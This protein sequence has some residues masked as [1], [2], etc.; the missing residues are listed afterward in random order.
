[1]KQAFNNK[2]LNKAT[3]RKWIYAAAISGVLITGVQAVKNV[4]NGSVD[5]KAAKASTKLPSSISVNI[6]YTDGTGNSSYISTKAYT[7]KL[8]T[9]NGK[10]VYDLTDIKNIQSA[11]LDVSRIPDYLDPN[12]ESQYKSNDAASNADYVF[13]TVTRKVAEDQANGKTTSSNKGTGTTTSSNNG[14][15]TTENTTNTSANTSSSKL[16]PVTF[17]NHYRPSDTATL[18]IDPQGR[19]SIDVTPNAPTENSNVPTALTGQNVYNF[20]TKFWHADPKSLPASI[21]LTDYNKKYEDYHLERPKVINFKDAKNN[22]VYSQTVYG[23]DDHPM[24]IGEVLDQFQTKYKY[25]EADPNNTYVKDRSIS[26]GINNDD[27][28]AFDILVKYK[29]N[30]PISGSNQTVEIKND[31]STMSDTDFKAKLAEQGYQLVDDD[32]PATVDFSN[33]GSYSVK[34]ITNS[35]PISFVDQHNGVVYSTNLPASA[36]NQ[37]ISIQDILDKVASMGVTPDTNNSIVQ[38]KQV[39]A[40]YNGKFVSIN[41]TAPVH[42]LTIKFI[43]KSNGNEVVAPLEKDNVTNFESFTIADKV[44]ELKT[45]NYVPEL[46]ALASGFNS[47]TYDNFS[48]S[49]VLNPSISVSADGTHTAT[50]YVDSTE[51]TTANTNK[52]GKGYPLSFKDANGNNISLT[53]NSVNPTMTPKEFQKALSDQGYTLSQADVD[54]LG[55]NSVDLNKSDTGLTIS[56]NSI[57]NNVHPIYVSYNDASGKNHTDVVNISSDNPTMS[58]DDL[59]KALSNQGY[60]LTDDQKN[61]LGQRVNFDSLDSRNPI[62]VTTN[63]DA[64]VTKSYPQS[65]EYN[66]G[67]GNIQPIS[68][69]IDSSS[70]NMSKDAY[71][72]AL[73][74]KGYALTDDQKNKLPDVIDLTSNGTTVVTAKDNPQTSHTQTLKDNNNNDVIVHINSSTSTISAYEYEKQLSDQGVTLSQDSK[75]KIAN[76]SVDLTDSTPGYTVTKSTD[77][78]S[79]K[80]YPQ[81]VNV[82]KSDGSYVP[83]SISITSGTSVISRDEYISKLKSLG[84]DVS[85][86]D[87]IP[88]NVDLDNNKGGYSVEQPSSDAPISYKQMVVLPDNSQVAVYINSKTP[89]ISRDDLVKALADQGYTLTD[90]GSTSYTLGSTSNPISVKPNAQAVTTH[91]QTVKIANGD[92]TFAT[93]TVYIPSSNGQLTAS[94]YF[95]AMS[96]QGYTISDPSALSDP[97]SV[98]SDNI[99]PVVVPNAVAHSV[100]INVDGQQ[101]TINV[102]SQNPY[103]NK[104]DFLNAVSAQ[105]YTISDPNSLPS[106]VQL[107]TK[108]VYNAEN[109][110]P[111][112]YIFTFNS[113]DKTKSVEISHDTPL[114]TKQDLIKQLQQKGFNITDSGQLNDIIN[115]NNPDDTSKVASLIEGFST[116]KMTVGVVGSGNTISIS[117]NN[118]TISKQDFINRVE[119]NGYKV[120]NP[121]VLGDKL[122]LTDPTNFSGLI[123]AKAENVSGDTNSNKDDSNN[124]ESNARYAQDVKVAGSN[125]VVKVE[126]TNK[127]MTKDDFVKYLASKGYK[128]SDASKLP[129]TIDLTKSLD[130]IEVVSDKAQTTTNNTESNSSNSGQ[131]NSNVSNSNESNARYAQDVKVAGSN[132]VVKVESTNKTMTKDD[133]VKYLASKG[134]KVSDASKLPATIDLTKSLDG[135][136][137]VSDKVQTT[138]NNTESNSSN[139]GQT[140]SNVSNSNESN[141][142]YA[143]DVKVAGSNEV[144]KVESANKTMT[145]DDFVKYLASK[146]YKV[147][148]ASKLPATIDLTKSLDGIEVVSDKAQSTN[149]NSKDKEQARKT[150]TQYVKIAGSNKAIKVESANKTITKNEFIKYLA[151]KGYKVSDASKLPATIDLT[152]SIKGIEVVSKSS[153]KASKKD[154]KNNNNNVRNETDHRGQLNNNEGTKKLPQTGDNTNQSRSFGFGLISIVLGFILA[155]FGLRRKD[156]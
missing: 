84:Y 124:N 31:S 77:N 136:E 112:G 20:L 24:T 116:Y 123:I 146:G 111:G 88:E 128:V 23:A 102:G 54:K 21:S 47:Q 99:N 6:L 139:S 141:A 52:T 109:N 150:Y 133:F 43:D 85:N 104:S 64:N 65:L 96:D 48:E 140:N 100:L 83:T 155:I 117:S 152:K 70:Q 107:D 89:T 73:S 3:S 7:A 106:Q 38:N 135:I 42:K 78:N 28:Q 46:S 25:A 154:V 59:A 101:K 29:M 50:I 151:A 82:K 62:Q 19:Q 40:F 66:D 156:K 110:N 95:K 92:G 22:V 113:S 56:N 44:N 91:P 39:P 134:Y 74:D 36:I 90:N 58:T 115:L 114:I 142:T 103:L 143:Q 68:V 125:E 122:D 57:S 30:I 5:A 32:I 71:I 69:S 8:V 105:G 60:K 26:S 61:Q 108:T 15:N 87:N 149:N 145:K 55:S 129:A 41:V 14:S 138:N 126:S 148:D 10:Q 34:A 12:N 144:V 76:G 4:D 127:T 51:A 1:M 2:K 45:K 86:K 75:D 67:K 17:Y 93:K 131:T 130:G 121:D 18:F 80:S 11:F 49:Y 132:E 33:P 9:V 35:L 81:T 72:K 16:V 153:R 147:S 53:I 13:Q 37:P 79:A 120:M 63:A 97:L 94:E 137:V 98:A 119:Q 118:K 27:N